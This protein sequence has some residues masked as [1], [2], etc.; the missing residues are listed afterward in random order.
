MVGHGSR[1]EEANEDVR[2]AA[3]QIRTHGRFPLVVA[4]FLEIAQPTI[5]EGFRATNLA[6]KY[7]TGELPMPRDF[8]ERLC[9]DHY[10]RTHPR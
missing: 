10:Y 3:L 4:A 7:Y 2:Q 8:L 9:T 1:R 6:Y 5:A